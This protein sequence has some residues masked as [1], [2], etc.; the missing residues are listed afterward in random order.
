MFRV[1]S[2][3]E[4]IDY[5]PTWARTFEEVRARVE[6][7]LSSLA[8]RIEH[9]GS[10]A[11]PGLAAK[12]IVDIDVLLAADG[13]LREAIARLGNVGYRYEGTLGVPGREAF[14]PPADLPYHHLYVCHP[15]SEEFARHVAFRDYLRGNPHA[16][17]EYAE[18]KR[19]LAVKFRH[20]R[21]SYGE[22]KQ[23]FIKDALLRAKR[24]R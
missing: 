4:V 12:P 23:A 10:T 14:R 1:E 20:D 21:T 18:L 19:A 13:T 11:V 17:H 5:N 3:V 7:C 6:R 16:V 22:G 8:G 24:S 9:V 15:G 2:P